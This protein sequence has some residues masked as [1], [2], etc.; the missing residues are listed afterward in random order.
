MQMAPTPLDHGLF[1]ERTAHMSPV[2]QG[3]GNSARFSSSPL[4][5]PSGFYSGMGLF[6]PDLFWQGRMAQPN[7]RGR[8]SSSCLSGKV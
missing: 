3:R 7:T 1:I 6:G 4:L 2:K 5:S 8:E